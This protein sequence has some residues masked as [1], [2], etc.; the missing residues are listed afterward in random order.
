MWGKQQHTTVL[1][2]AWLKRK[3]K[4][5]SMMFGHKVGSI[6]TN[7]LQANHDYLV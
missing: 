2:D 4:A 7:V 3:L 1:M 6:P 5:N